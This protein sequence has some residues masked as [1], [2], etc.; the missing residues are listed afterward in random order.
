[1]PFVLD[2]ENSQT[3]SFIWSGSTFFYKRVNQLDKES[4]YSTASQRGNTNFPRFQREMVVRAVVGWD[5]V[6][7]PDGNPVSFSRGLISK[8]PGEFFT[9]FMDNFDEQFSRSED[10]R[11][12]R[13]KNFGTSYGLGPLSE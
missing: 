3:Y 2:P 13:E 6:V 10:E 4:A 7:D 5:D 12:N 11:M 8:M 9:D 1:M